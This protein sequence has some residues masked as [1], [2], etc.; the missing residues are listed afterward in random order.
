MIRRPPRSTLF[1]YTTLFRS[2]SVGRPRRRSLRKKVGYF[3]ACRSIYICNVH[4]PL[5]AEGAVGAVGDPLTVGRKRRSPGDGVVQ[6]LGRVSRCR[7]YDVDDVVWRRRLP[8]ALERNFAAP[9]Q[10]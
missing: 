10:R 7:V 2:R 3:A 1:S 5:V 8:T 6:Q 9:K 4:I